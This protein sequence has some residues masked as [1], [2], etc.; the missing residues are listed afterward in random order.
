MKQENL[1][2]VTLKNRKEKD[3]WGTESH[4]RTKKI[5]IPI[6]QWGLKHCPGKPS[7]WFLGIVWN[8]RQL[9]GQ[10]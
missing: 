4:K 9:T 1:M 2:L 3:F 5:Y 7:G 10:V 8:Q 6:Q